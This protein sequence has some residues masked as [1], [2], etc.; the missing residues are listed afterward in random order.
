LQ[1]YW[2]ISSEYNGL[3]RQLVGSA[4]LLIQTTQSTQKPIVLRITEKKIGGITYTITS[5]QSEYAKETA[6]KKISRLM[7]RHILDAENG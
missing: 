2:T 5:V 1:K 7:L 4:I 3:E 6:P